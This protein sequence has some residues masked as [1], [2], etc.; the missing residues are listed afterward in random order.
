VRD[1][2]A[3]APYARQLVD[4]MRAERREAV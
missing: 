2:K 4:H 3:L 1:Y